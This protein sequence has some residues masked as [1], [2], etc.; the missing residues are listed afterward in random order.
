[1]R[2]LVRKIDTHAKIVDLKATSNP[3]AAEDAQ[4]Q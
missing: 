1:M 3:N 2:E 4:I